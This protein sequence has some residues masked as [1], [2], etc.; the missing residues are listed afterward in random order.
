MLAAQSLVTW[1]IVVCCY[2]LSTALWWL[3]VVPRLRRGPGRDAAVG[4]VWRLSRWWLGWRQRPRFDGVAH[5]AAALDR[6]PVIV[7]AN[8]TGAVDP[9]LVQSATSVLIRWMMARD[10]MGAGMDDVWALARVIPVNRAGA[11]PG[12]LRQALRTLHSG[13]C[14]GIFPEGRITRPPG[15]LRPFHEGVGLLATR[16][17]ATV[18]PV[19]ISG[20]PDVDG[21]GGSMLG[22][23]R[24]Q[25]VFLEPVTYDRS[26]PPEAVSADLRTRL[27]QASG[28]QLVDEAM[29]LIL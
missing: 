15:S 20:T 8:H 14:V 21:I 16:T 18:L 11:D 26:H 24:S 27:A 3:L 13:G 12:S 29:P 28:W 10:M 25:V 17:G 19:W 1:G 4:L 9:F 22:R 6:G 2:V 7:V 23:S 5:L